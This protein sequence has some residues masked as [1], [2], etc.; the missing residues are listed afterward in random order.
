MARSVGIDLGAYSTKVVGLETAGKGYRIYHFSDTPVPQSAEEASPSDLLAS[1]FKDGRLP[2]DQAVLGLDAHASVIREITVPFTSKEQIRKIIKYESESHL[3][4]FG[5]DEVI[6]DFVQ[7]REHAD[8]SDLIVV[9]VVKEVLREKLSWVE[10]AKVEPIAADIDLLAHYNS[11]SITP[12]P[13]EHGAIALLDIGYRSMKLMVVEDGK[14]I[15]L[16]GIRGGYSSIIS[17][18]ARETNLTL[19]AAE[20]K[21]RT[22]IPEIADAV[23]PD[24]EGA[25]EMVVVDDDESFPEPSDIDRNR[26][27]LESELL[28][29]RMAAFR[30]RVVREVNRSL[31]RVPTKKPVELLLITGGGSTIPALDETIA[32]GIGIPV[33]PFDILDYVDHPFDDGERASVEPFVSVPLGLALKPI[34]GDASG[35]QFRREEYA[36]QKRFEAIKVPL[37]ACLVAL[38]LFLGVIW[39]IF[40]WQ[41][42]LRRD[43]YDRINYR[44]AQA[45]ALDLKL[46]DFQK[47]V[48][49]NRP[50]GEGRPRIRVS[51]IGKDPLRRH[52]TLQSKLTT[53]RLNADRDMGQTDAADVHH[54]ALDTWNEVFRCFAEM[55]KI[56]GK[57]T[58]PIIPS[59]RF[60]QQ[61]AVCNMILRD[62]SERVPL[63][64]V[65]ESSKL[66]KYGSQRSARAYDK[67]PDAPNATL[68]SQ[69]RFEFRDGGGQ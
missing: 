31:A 29:Q 58:S 65:L 22:L 23:R 66:L 32:A 4:S 19:P 10:A 15:Q 8:S 17:A 63:I 24:L 18:V 16:R 14:P 2:R 69:F 46:P 36:F 11:L 48:E 60:D 62:P 64:K 30:Q 6:V 21:V 1:T 27:D 12:Y 37:T 28:V 55:Q 3:F 47:Y 41:Y 57:T 9:A 44:V 51:K 7:V 68:Y 54:C 40:R 38:L 61:G 25:E 13:K 59:I 33:K 42:E 50:D 56:T 20:T 49:P 26:D 35:T 52:R 45:A 5:I 39:Y 53:A 34:G 67:I 43:E